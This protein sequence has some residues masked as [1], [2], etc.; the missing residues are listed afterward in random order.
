M[1]KNVLMG[2]FFS[3][4]GAQLPA[5]AG[6]ADEAAEELRAQIG[7]V[8]SLCESKGYPPVMRDAQ[9]TDEEYLLT[10]IKSFSATENWALASLLRAPKDAEGFVVTETESAL[11]NTALNQLR[12]RFAE[13]GLEWAHIPPSSDP[14]FPTLE[15]VL[16]LSVWEQ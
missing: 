11:R 12:P 15:G 10:A 5:L 14:Q 8:Q 3:F 2:L 4:M 7:Y 16:A 13:H 1:K 9:S 6:G